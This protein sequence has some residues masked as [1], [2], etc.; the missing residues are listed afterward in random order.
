LK[1]ECKYLTKDYLDYLRSFRLR[2]QEHV[3]LDFNPEN[4]RGFE[5]DIGPIVIHVKGLWV[6]TILYEIPLLALVSEAYFKF[7]DTAWTH[8]GQLEGAR[9]KGERLLQAGCTFSEFG[10]RRRRDYHTQELVVRGLKQAAEEGKK[11]GWTGKLSGTSNVHFAMRFGLMP[12]GTVAHEWFMGVAAI[13]DDYENANETALRYW[14]ETFGVGVSHALEAILQKQ[15][16]N[17]SRSL[18]LR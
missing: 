18:E 15:L 2:P 4:D 10:S 8:D 9:T 14:I 12:I 5:A 6:E 11:E 3:K 13:T 16:I 7:Q 17:M 1:S